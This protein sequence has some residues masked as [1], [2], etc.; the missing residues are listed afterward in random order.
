MKTQTIGSK[1]LAIGLLLL[2]SISVRAQTNVTTWHNDLARTGANTQETTLT[3]ANVNV[4]NFGKLFS[5]AV[6]GE[7]YA[8]PL[9]LSGVSIGGGTHNVAYI[10]TEHDSVYAIDADSGAI[11]AQV[12]L[13]PTGGTTV[14]SSSDLNCGDI[15]PEVGIT[16]TPVIDPASNTLYVVSKAK[17]NGSIVQNLHALS[18]LTL[19]EKLGGPVEIQAA[20]SGTAKDGSGTTVTF[21]PVLEN[22]RP[23]LA[24][25]NGHVLVTWGAHCDN[26]PYHGWLISYSASSLAQEAVWNTTPD[27]EPNGSTQ[28]PQGGIWMAG[29]APAVDAS[30]DIYVTSGNGYWNGGRDFSDSVLKLG[31][32]ANNTFPLLDYFTPFDQGG[33]G[34]SDVGSAGVLLFPTTSAGVQLL[35]QQGKQGT[36]YLVDRNGLGKDCVNL[37]PACT[38]TDTQIPEELRN[39]T[40]GVLSSP[41][42]WNGHVYW[43]SYEFLTAWSVDPASGLISSAPA[44][45][46]A[47]S[48]ARTAGASL[49]A[50]GTTNGIVWIMQNTGELF[51]FDA[52]NLSNVLWTSG[53]APN[54]RDRADSSVKFEPPTIVN[55]KVYYGTADEVVA[56]GLLAGTAPSAATPTFSPGG[57]T[58]NGPQS[59][60]IAEATSSAQVHYTTNGTTPTTASTLYTG[61]IAVGSS[62]TLEAIAV[63]SGLTNSGV[64]SATYTIQQSGGTTAT[65]SFAPAAGTYTATQSVTIS[66]ATSGATIYYTTNGTTPTTA[67]TR[68]AGPISV[69]ASETLEAIAVASGLTASPA[70]TAAYTINAGGGGSGTSPVSYPT[71]FAS[72]TGFTLDGGATVTGGALQLTDGGTF[73]A[74][75]IWYSTALNIQ[76]FTT[77]FTFQITPAGANAT[78][79]MTFAIQ[80]QGLT[81][82]G[83]I[84]G[85]LGYQGVTPSVAVKF[86]TFNNS[87]EGVN[88]TGFYTDGAA[89][90]V[91]ALD[92]T[93]SGVNLHSGDVMHVHLTYDGTTLTLTLTDTV[94]NATFTASQ[95][96][97]IPATVGANTAYVGFTGGT[98]GTVST[99]NILSWTY[100]PG[101]SSAQPATP[102][103][104]PTFMPA[105]GTYTGP[106]SALIQDAT[107]GATIYYTTN[108]TAPTTASTVYTGPFIVSNTGTLKAMAVASGH[109]ASAASTASYT[110]NSTGGG[111]SGGGTNPPA[112]NYPTGFT[113]ATNLAL[114]GGPTLAAGALELT[115]GG[116]FE[117]RAIWYSTP[118]N[119]QQF[120]TDFTFQ[121]TPAAANATDGMTFTMQNQGLTAHGGIGGALGYQGVKPSVAVKFD[122]F[123]NSGE[124]VNSTGF[125]TNGAAPTVPATDLTPSG[126]NL[127]SGHVMHAHLTYDGTTL[128]LTLTDTV[129]SATFTASQ[130]INIPGTVGANTALVGFTAGTGG[131]VSTQEVLSWTYQVN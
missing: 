112:V 129:T 27:G 47:Q 23:G 9:Y 83:G 39:A 105:S 36:V 82:H 52:T 26:P 113:S 14:N 43:P 77:D 32:P 89:P 123:N 124:G 31:P 13:I 76:Q 110:I 55:G 118:V 100:T 16:G 12:S 61:P 84:G 119:I 104:A 88:S 7:V 44:S 94:T 34:D 22:Q 10:A 60:T 33:P 40:P 101:G 106:Q 69:S 131:T 42:Y 121:I 97:N 73:E 85:A 21:D 108:G 99:Q 35:A 64:G 29:A 30:G 70:A 92:L 57:G 115:D 3:T 41:M 46:S 86:D 1:G 17:V 81:A 126:V 51:A 58:Y 68:Y 53:Q 54:G 98:G 75:A 66:D 18:T 117:A 67:S 62:E 71:G 25:E 80:N 5:T 127:H 6:D 49:S 48:F 56:Y 65:P 91:P 24:L 4:N 114:V 59:V 103:A 130:A 122:T 72:A 116:T 111:S 20:V 95:A 11:Y 78:D 19:A 2:A 38:N 125:Y 96:I 63:A 93:S 50:N 87:G 37:S 128:T 90:T 15:N 8:Q 74:R 107:S 109:T 79:G 45:Q 102:T 120:S 28:S